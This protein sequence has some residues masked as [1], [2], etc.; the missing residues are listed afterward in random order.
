MKITN[1]SRG[2]R[3]KLDAAAAEKKVD[4]IVIRAVD[5][6]TRLQLVVVLID[7]DSLEVEPET[8]NIVETKSDVADIDIVLECI[9]AGVAADRPHNAEASDIKIVQREKRD[10]VFTAKAIG[11]HARGRYGHALTGHDR[12]VVTL[13][14][15]SPFRTAA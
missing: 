5:F 6:K 9:A 11:Q 8:L 7:R 13:G 2:H 12:D 10:I 4:F 14:D 3:V 1:W 15:A